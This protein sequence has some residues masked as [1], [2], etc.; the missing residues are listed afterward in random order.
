[1]GGI[2]V[3]SE[4][5]AQ[6]RDRAVAGDQEAIAQIAAAKEGNGDAAYLLALLTASGF[7]VAQDLKAAL[8]HLQR[9]AERGHQRAQAEL[10]ALVGNWR[11]A[12]EISSG[13]TPPPGTWARLKAAVDIAAWLRVPAG[14]AFSTAPRIAAVKDFISAPACD[15]LIG[16]GRPH[17][18]HADIFDSATGELVLD[19]RR[20]NNAAPLKIDRIDVVLAFVRARIAALAELPVLALEDSQILHYEVGQQFNP[21]YDFFD[22]KFPALAREVERRGQRALTLL[23]YLNDNYEGGDTAFPVLGRAFKGRKGDALIFWNLGEDGAPDYRTQHTGT[24]PTRGEKWLFS[25]W[26]RVRGSAPADPLR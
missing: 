4:L 25:Q 21:H 24:A 2:T 9:A 5:L 12:R 18:K 10:A 8:E 16:L 1:M 11:L 13:K 23:I 17:L 6:W 20:S 19:G 22:V 14:R 15:W 3:D 7:G 26:I